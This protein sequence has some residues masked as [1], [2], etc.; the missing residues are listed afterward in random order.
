MKTNLKLSSK[1]HLFIIVSSVLIA[2]GI[3]VG[4]ICH[5][6]AN[7]YFNYG[8]DWASYKEVTV[9]YAYVDY[10]DES[11]VIEICNKNFSD[12]GLKYQSLTTG[13]SSEGGEIVYTFSIAADDTQLSNAVVLIGAAFNGAIQTSVSAHT[14]EALLGGALTIDRCCIA[15]AC[16][17]VVHFLYFVIRYK[18]TMALAAVLA[19]I[20]NL[21]IFL[22]LL[23]LTR[24]PVASSVL[25]FAALTLLITVIGTSLLFD[26]MR[27]NAKN[28]DL[29]K[30][31]AFEH[32][33]LGANECL[34][35]NLI[36]PACLA[37]VAALLFVLLSISSLSP[38]VILAPVFA[39]LVSFIS[40]AYGTVFFTPSVYSRFKLLGDNYKSQHARA[41]KTKGT[42]K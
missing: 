36:I 6:V 20:H 40:C 19:D 3:M 23:S 7:G 8:G 15:L 31:S 34:T 1:M 32:A 29:K 27:R 22:S 14:Q 38:V 35:L 41:S 2:L 16:I 4:V 26:R 13:K 21:G 12:C 42:S 5:F 30:L 28:E 24:I 25:A 33:D 9:S 17:I 18:F 39:A 37:S 11:E 10:T